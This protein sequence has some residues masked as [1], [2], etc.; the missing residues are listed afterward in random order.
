MVFCGVSVVVEEVVVVGCGGGGG[1]EVE[2]WW[3]VVK[4]DCYVFVW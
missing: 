1:V 2:V 4:C 3:S